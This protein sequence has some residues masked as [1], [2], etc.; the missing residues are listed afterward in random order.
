MNEMVKQRGKSDC[1]IAAIASVTGQSYASV[2][3]RYGRVDRG[4]MLSHELEWLLS[5]FAT[6]KKCRVRK[7]LTLAKFVSC[8]TT[9]CYVITVGALGGVF[10]ELHA[11]GLVDG[12]AGNAEGCEDWDVLEVYQIK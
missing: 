5:E 12:I 8:H 10:G 1:G 11:V 3:A 9:G 6:F 4:G 7:R 2:K